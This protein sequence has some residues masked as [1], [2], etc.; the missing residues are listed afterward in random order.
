VRKYEQTALAPGAA[1]MFLSAV[2][3]FLVKYRYD[4][5]KVH[6]AMKQ[7]DYKLKSADCSL[8]CF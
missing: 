5:A 7:A 1:I 2:F 4:C 8:F 3:W 6:S